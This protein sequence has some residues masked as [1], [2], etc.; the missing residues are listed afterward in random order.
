MMESGHTV[1]FS[2]CGSYIID[3]VTD[4]NI[5]SDKSWTFHI[6]HL[7]GGCVFPFFGRGASHILCQNTRD[8]KEQRK[9]SMRVWTARIIKKCTTKIIKRWT[10]RTIRMW[11]TRI[12]RRWTT[13]I[14]RRWTARIIR[15]WTAR[16]IKKCTTKIIWRWTTRII[17]RWTT[18]DARRGSSRP[19]GAEGQDDAVLAKSVITVEE[20]NQR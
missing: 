17:R 1:V 3:D 7:G 10:T 5:Q 11:T 18:R 14:I 4:E 9:R 8:Q 13:T 15:R 20:Q 19:E 16:I 6:E 12:I 2:T